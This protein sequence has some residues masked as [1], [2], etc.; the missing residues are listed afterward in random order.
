LKPVDRFTDWQRFQTLASELISSRI[1]INSEGRSNKTAG[2]FIASIALA[3]RLSTS[4]ITLSDPYNN[5]PGPENP[6]QHKKRLRRLWQI[7]WNPECKTTVNWVTKT[8]RQMTHTKTFEQLE[9][10]V[11]NCDVTPKALWH[12]VNSLTERDGP[13]APTAVHG[14]LGITYHMNKR[15]NV[16]ADC[17]ENQ[18]TSHDL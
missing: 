13:M 1:Q 16:I 17:L 12:T 3:Y 14:P 15:A 4:K 18:F 10:K 2:D 11:G 5:L 6:L 9:T 7:T 8:I